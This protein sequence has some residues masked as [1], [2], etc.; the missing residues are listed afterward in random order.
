M[1]VACYWIGK[2][3]LYVM[4]RCVVS[5]T[6]CVLVP[7]GM[8]AGMDDGD[9]RVNVSTSVACLFIGYGIFVS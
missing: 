2:F 5:I 8:M 4:L 1:T 7:S 6:T 9:A 3:S